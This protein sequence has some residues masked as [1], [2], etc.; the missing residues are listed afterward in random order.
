MAEKRC[1]VCKETKDIDLFGPEPTNH[2]KDGHRCRCRACGNEIAR[3]ARIKKA[4]EEGREL[5]F[6]PT[7][8]QYDE[9]GNCIGRKCSVCRVIKPAGEF[10]KDPK[11]K[12]GITH[13]CK[14]CCSNNGKIYRERYKDVVKQ[15]KKVYASKPEAR[16]LANE[17]L[18]RWRQKPDSKRKEV[19]YDK[20]Y[21]TRPYVA[22]RRRH[23]SIERRARELHADGSHTLEEWKWLLSNFHYCFK[24]GSIINLTRDH[25]IPLAKG[26]SNFIDNIQVLCFGCNASKRDH[27]IIDYRPREARL[28]AFMQ[29]QEAC[30]AS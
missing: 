4:Q 13:R 26:G 16:R 30:I 22:E 25:I 27:I 28:W 29:V 9:A 1:S 23:K 14:V 24:C 2:S 5:K 6:Y 10:R 3:L 7:D 15:R 12:A 17:G 11:R 19:E 18:R 21:T 20:E 8:Y